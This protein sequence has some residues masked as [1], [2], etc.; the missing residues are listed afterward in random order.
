MKL[1]LVHGRAQAG[2]DPVKLKAEWIE[3]LE[4]G[5]RKAG[6]SLPADV[7]VDFPFYGDQLDA[8]VRQFDLPAEPGFMPKGSPAFDEYAEFRRQIAEEMRLRA[9]ISDQEVRGEM[10]PVPTEKGVENWAW[11]Q[12]IVRLL[13]R[14]LTGISATTIEI[15]LRDVF[16]YTRRDVV[17]RAIDKTVAAM[18][19]GDTAV[20]VGHSLGSV[21]AYNVIKAAPR[22]VPLYVTVGSPLSIRAVRQPLLPISNPVGGRGWYNALD[23]HDIVA[24]YPLDREN[25]GV[26]PAITNFS[27]VDNWTENHHGIVG[28]LDDVDVARAIYAGLQTS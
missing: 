11:V 24:L 25:F 20:V 17:R 3:A 6:L 23:P 13:D 4:K 2:K 8:F 15:F 21:V 28:Y 22:K 14:H 5:L 9:G 1:L 27:G 19:T 26:E 16:L 10:G 7:E 12:A 18:L